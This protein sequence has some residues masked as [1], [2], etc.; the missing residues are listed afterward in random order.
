[1]DISTLWSGLAHI[2]VSLLTLSLEEFVCL[3]E[4]EASVFVRFTRSRY[5]KAYFQEFLLTL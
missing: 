1:M 4:Y 5:S 3:N 2:G